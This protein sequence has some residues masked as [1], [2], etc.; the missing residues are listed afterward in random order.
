[1]HF[2]LVFQCQ[3]PLLSN[4]VWIRCTG[5]F[6]CRKES[7]SMAFLKLFC[8]EGTVFFHCIVNIILNGLR[9]DI[10]CWLRMI[11]FCSRK[12]PNPSPS[13]ICERPHV[14][15]LCWTITTFLKLMTGTMVFTFVSSL[16]VI[17]NVMATFMGKCFTPS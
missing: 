6:F 13:I 17:Y 3:L 5:S 12:P 1:M 14:D 4:S 16:S 10:R 9:D 11:V 8:C 15:Q 7:N 2:C